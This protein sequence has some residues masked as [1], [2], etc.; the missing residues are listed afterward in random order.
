[1]RKSGGVEHHHGLA[2]KARDEDPVALGVVGDG[3]QLI[4]RQRRGVD[5]HRGEQGLRGPVVDRQ[6]LG[7]TVDEVEPVVDQVEG[8][9]TEIRG[10]G[11]HDRIAPRVEDA[12]RPA[13]VVGDVEATACRVEGE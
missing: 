8:R 1:M 7:A 11:A 3:D 6:E 2:R 9:T 5:G 13:A 10:Q 4:R 12:Q